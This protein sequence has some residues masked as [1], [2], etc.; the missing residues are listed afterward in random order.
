VAISD[1]F[2]LQRFVD[3]QHG[4]IETALAEIRAGTKQSHW[5]WFVFPQ[6]AELGRSPTAKLFGIKSADEARA[7]ID[8][9]ILGTRLRSC[10]ETLLPWSSKRTAE[11]VFGGIDS[12]KLRSSLTLFDAIE[13]HALFDQALMNFFGGERD[14]LTLA[15][16]D[17][18]Q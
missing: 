6:L 14:E 13:P 3:A 5:M 15:L 8:H 2:N 4:V 1:P 17:R 9:P 16:L 11:Q 10:V 18:Q 7:Y 12:T